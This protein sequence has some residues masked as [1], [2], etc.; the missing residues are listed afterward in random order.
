MELH[1]PSLFKC[2]L[3]MSSSTSVSLPSSRCSLCS[4]WYVILKDSFSGK[5]IGK[6]ITEHLALFTL[7]SIFDTCFP[8]LFTNRPLFSWTLTVLQ[9]DVWNSV[10]LLFTGL[11]NINSISA[12]RKLWLFHLLFPLRILEV[13]AARRLQCDFY[14]PHHLF[15]LG[16]TVS[17]WTFLFVGSSI[18]K[19][20]I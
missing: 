18:T 13:I 4:Q 10:L 12:L 2:S 15:L 3:I 8:A 7:L 14:V 19:L 9:K 20:P 5:D 17:S 11:A 6:E 1:I 16:S